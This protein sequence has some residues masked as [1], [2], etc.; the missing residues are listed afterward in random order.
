[1][2]VLGGVRNGSAVAVTVRPLVTVLGA[3]VKF[4]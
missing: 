3:G 1:M 4:D 2:R